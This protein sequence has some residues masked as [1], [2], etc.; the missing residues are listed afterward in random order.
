MKFLFGNAM[1]HLLM[2]SDAVTKVIMLS[3]LIA[4]IICWTVIFYKWV[5]LSEKS[6]QLTELLTKME[7]VHSSSDLERIINQS[8]NL[9]GTTLLVEYT[10]QVKKF[11]TSKQTLGSYERE[12]LDEKRYGIVD[13]LVFQESSYLL[14][15]FIAAACGPLVGLFGTVW[16][17]MHSFMSIAQKHTADIV[18]VAPGIAEALLTTLAGLMVAIPAMIMYHYLVHLV[19][20]LEHD[21]YRL[22]D[23]VVHTTSSV[24]PTA[25][26]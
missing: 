19:R 12:L 24:M 11:V 2:Q 5:Q 26:E 1:W 13:E 10:D 18:T 25:K 3:L 23:L 21:L 6:K 20:L 9:Y 15:L 16:G 4:S 14:I 17:L 7:R 22:S 8:S